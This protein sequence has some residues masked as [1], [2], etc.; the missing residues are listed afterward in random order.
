MIQQFLEKAQRLKSLSEE[1][2]VAKMLED[3]EA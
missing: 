3:E 2:F 1:E